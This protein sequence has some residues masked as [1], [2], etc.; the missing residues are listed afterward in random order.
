MKDRSKGDEENENDIDR[1]LRGEIGGEIKSP[2]TKV[3]KRR[4]MSI[5]EKTRAIG[6]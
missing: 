5:G 6:M 2:I 4:G 3:R 1:Y